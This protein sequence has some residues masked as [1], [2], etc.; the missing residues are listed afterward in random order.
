MQTQWGK[1]RVGQ[2]EKVALKYIHYHVKQIASGKLLYN[3]GKLMLCS[4]TT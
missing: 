3:T 2:I 1:E 4:V